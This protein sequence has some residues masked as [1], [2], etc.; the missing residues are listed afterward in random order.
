MQQDLPDDCLIYCLVF[1]SKH[2]DSCGI[3]PL[4]GC[5]SPRTRGD[6]QTGVCPVEGHRARGWSSV[7]CKE[8][9]LPRS[10]ETSSLEDIQTL[11]V[12]AHAQPP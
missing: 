7:V 4:D 11:M 6:C 3:S 9:R 1:V 10:C 12:Q 5:E 8:H 2:A